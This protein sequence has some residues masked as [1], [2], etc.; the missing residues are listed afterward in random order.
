MTLILSKSCINYVIQV[1]DRLVTQSQ[2][3]FDELANKSIVYCAYNGILSISYTGHA[4]I[5][6]LPTDQ[7][8]A[9]KLLGESFPRDR[10][11]PAIG[12][13]KTKFVYIGPAFQ[14]LKEEFNKAYHTEIKSEFRN[15][16]VDKSFDLCIDGF[17]WGSKGNYRP[18]AAWLSKP[19]RSEIFEYGCRPRRWYLGGRFAVSAAPSLNISKDI[20]QS[21]VDQLAN[22]NFNEAEENLVNA[23]REISKSNPL[24]GGDCMSILLPPPNVAQNSPVRVKFIPING[25]KAILHSN[26]RQTII[27]VAYTPWLIGPGSFSSPSIISG[28]GIEIGLCYYKVTFDAPQDSQVL[29][30][31]SSLER[32]KI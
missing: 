25:G 30:V 21:L 16:W 20:M 1:S 15:D 6:S 22:K 12:F 8:I 2:E 7:W 18:F 23:I 17:V 13:G 3:N 10:K 14:M 5:G 29:A 27:N 9:E 26:T 31:F 19:Q 32:P 24:V 4:F 11:P 28:K